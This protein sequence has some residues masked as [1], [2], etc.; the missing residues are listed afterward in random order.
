MKAKAGRFGITPAFVHGKQADAGITASA[1]VV[2]P[3][4]T[5]HRKLFVEKAGV[6]MVTLPA[7][8]AAITA[9]LQKKPVGTAAVALTAATS[10]VV[11]TQTAYVVGN[12]VILSTLTDGQRIINEGD[13][14]YW[15]LTA[16]GTVTTQP[17]GFIGTVE[18]SILE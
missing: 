2:V 15:D 16:A 5:P 18:V 7:G 1:T 13:S 6:L 9:T 17:V 10:L 8:S 12:A 4:G 3:V 11:A 14:L